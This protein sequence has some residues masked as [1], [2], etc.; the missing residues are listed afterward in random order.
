MFHIS[1]IISRHRVF[2]VYIGSLLWLATATLTFSLKSGSTL[3]NLWMLLGLISGCILT[4]A[5]AWRVIS[6]AQLAPAA[7]PFLIDKPDR[8]RNTALWGLVVLYVALV[9]IHFS[10]LGFI[11]IIRALHSG[12]DIEVSIVRQ[13]GYFELPLLLRYATDYSVKAVGP[14]LLLLTYY[15]RS[16]LFWIVLATS[17]IYSLGLFA[18]ILPVFLFFPLLVY[19]LMQRRWLHLVGTFAIMF[20]I[21]SSVT[22][23]ASI[24][25]RD[26]LVKTPHELK[27]VPEVI[28]RRDELIQQPDQLT[29]QLPTVN[30]PSNWHH[31]SVLFALYER[32][33]I[34]PAQVMHQWLQYYG[35]SDQREHGCGYRWLAPI[36][37]CAYVHIPN[38]LYNFYYHGNIDKGVMGSL[39]SASF[40]TEYANFGPSGF[41]L[42]ALFA[43]LLFSVIILI[44]GNHPMALPMTL[45]LIISLMETSLFT[46]INSGSGWLAMTLIFIL[47]FRLPTNEQP[48]TPAA[49]SA[50]QP[51]PD[52]HVRPRNRL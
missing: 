25:L 7:S 28:E 42:S 9:F 2:A 18:R 11:P 30:E 29:E 49:V 32:T 10:F 46:A 24:T 52:G 20:A 15:F 47:F 36:L 34:V 4:Y 17:V 13:E 16:R 21:L 22:I 33:L 35:N 14:G 51:L 50:V 5:G 6:R 43:G 3:T 1:S 19:Q 12:S 48:R 27:E 37:G 38:K 39:N 41:I 44:Y 26:S 23:I 8:M 45:P 31:T 40:M